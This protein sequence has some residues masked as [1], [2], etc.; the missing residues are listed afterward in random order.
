MSMAWNEGVARL[1][2]LGGG[3]VS[4]E[5]GVSVLLHPVLRVVDTV[6]VVHGVLRSVGEPRS[7]DGRHL[8][9]QRTGGQRGVQSE[10]DQA[11][12]RGNSHPG[13]ARTA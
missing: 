2:D 10:K 4:V 13:A 8:E 6:V 9:S 11:S 5:A 3:D 12:L 1:T 7:V